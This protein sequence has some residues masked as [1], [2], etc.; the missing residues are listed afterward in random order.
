MAIKIIA[1]IGV[2]HNGSLEIAKQLVD[3]AADAGADF[4]KFQTWKAE[5][6]VSR[7]AEKAAYQMKTTDRSESQLEMIKRLE[8]SPEMH[9]E[10]LQY[11]KEKEVQFLSTP[12]DMGSIDYLVSLGLTTL[13][14]GS[15]E[16]T[17]APYLVKIA[18]TG[19]DLILSTGMSSLEDVETALGAIAFGLTR[20]TEQ[21]SVEKFR[22]ALESPDAQEL[23]ARKVSLLHCT[24]SYPA[25]SESVN[26]KAMCALHEKFGIPVGYSDHTEGLAVSVAAA[27]LGASIIEKH[28]TLDRHLPGPDHQASIEPSELVELVR[29]VRSVE[30]ALGDGAKKPSAAE[31]D[32][33]PIARRSLVAAGSIRKGELFTEDNVTI[34]RPGTGVSPLL[35][36]EI[37]G[38]PANR[39]YEEDELLDNILKVR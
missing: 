23:L 35:Y 39:D 32:I 10:L 30:S 3:V 7:N 21:P 29:Q 8:L 26:L 15:S 34:K 18:R 20:R 27:A 6:H 1:E 9:V 19:C 25:P 14:I 5:R 36:W 22:E 13:K 31:M 37:L 28:C 33:I 17:N 38:K 16:V 24:T 12:F 11:A 4:V 2:N